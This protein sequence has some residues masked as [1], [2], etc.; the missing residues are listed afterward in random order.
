MKKYL[1][2]YFA[3]S[4]ASVL[5]YS[6]AG[7]SG[8]GLKTFSR[9]PNLSSCESHFLYNSSC[10]IMLRSIAVPTFFILALPF[11]LFYYPGVYIFAIFLCILCSQR[12]V[13]APPDRTRVA[14]Q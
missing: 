10:S 11:D 8:V 12:L 3:R 6:D 13:V 7:Y 4:F 5:S 2:I 1:G 9:S 14:N